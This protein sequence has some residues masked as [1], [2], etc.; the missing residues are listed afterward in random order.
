M[1]EAILAKTALVFCGMKAVNIRL[2]WSLADELIRTE[3][4]TVLSKLSTNARECQRAIWAMSITGLNWAPVQREG[5][6]DLWA[7]VKAARNRKTSIAVDRVY[8]VL[9][10]LEEDVRRQIKVDCSKENQLNPARTYLRWA[11]LLLQERLNLDLLGQVSSQSRPPGLPFWCPDFGSRPTDWLI[12]S[13][14][15]ESGYL[16]HHPDKLTHISTSLDGLEIAFWA[17]RSTKFRK[18]RRKAF[19]RLST[20]R[21][22]T[23]TLRQ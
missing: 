18:L 17:L 2:I 19:Q 23:R 16:T 1:Q 4:G 6:S 7:I 20:C 14:Q 22:V 9:G 8:G 10:L 3:L 21:Q 5:R 12:S 13:P 11:H 15:N